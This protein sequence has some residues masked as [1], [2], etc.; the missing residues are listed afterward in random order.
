[1]V[2][3]ARTPEDWNTEHVALIHKGKSK[4]TLDNYRGIAVSS[5]VGKLLTRL[6]TNRLNVNVEEGDMGKV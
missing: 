2:K 5:C 4:Y 1:M 3:D 6:L